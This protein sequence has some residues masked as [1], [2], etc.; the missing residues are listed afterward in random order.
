M[1]WFICA[2]FLALWLVSM[3]TS[4]TLGGLAHL[5]LVAAIGV[6]LVQVWHGRSVI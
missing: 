6:M 3:A 5:L 4:I 2:V 1:L